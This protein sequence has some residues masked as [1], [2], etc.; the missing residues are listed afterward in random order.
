MRLPPLQEVLPE[1]YLAAVLH[2]E[3]RRFQVHPGVDPLAILGATWAN[4]RAGRRVRGGSTLTMQVIRMARRKPRTYL[5][6]LIEGLQAVRFELHHSKEEILRHYATHVPMGGNIVGVEAASWRY[7]GRPFVDLSWAE[8]ALFAV[9]PNNPSLINLR[10]GR[11]L[12]RVKRDKLLKVMFDRKVFDAATYALACLEPLPPQARPLPF[13][14]PHFTEL[15]L[16]RSSPQQYLTTT[17]DLEVQMVL[18]H[19]ARPHGES[20]RRQGITNLAAIVVDSASGKVRGY[21]GSLDYFS[22]QDQG[23]VDGVLARRSTGSL[24]KPFLVAKVFDRGPFT[25]NSRIQDVPTFYGTF[26][27]QNASKTYQGFA[28]ISEV[29]QKSLNVPAVRLLHTYGVENFL[30]FLHQTGFRGLFRSAEQYGL[31]L[32]LGGAEA[33]L[34]ELTRAY[35]SFNHGGRRKDLVL[36]ERV[37]QQQEVPVQLF[38]AGSAHLVTEI[39]MEV[40]RPGIY[41]DQPH[42]S[43]ARSFAWKTGTSY[44]QKDA[45]AIGYDGQWTIGVWCGN[46]DGT[47]NADLSGVT[48]AGPLLLHLFQTLSKGENRT[49]PQ[50]PDGELRSISC[51]MRSGYPTGPHCPETVPVFVPREQQVLRN[52][53]YHQRIQVE[54]GGRYRLCSKCWEGRM[55]EYVTRF[56]P[57]AS[58]AAVYRDHGIPVDEFPAHLPGCPSDSASE[59]FELVYPVPGLTIS[60][61]RNF[62]GVRE[63]VV[64]SAHHQRKTAS[65]FW[66]LDGH[67]ITETQ[68][69]HAIAIEVSA[70]KHSLTVQDEQGGTRIAPFNLQ[71]DD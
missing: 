31:T 6:K 62:D 24:L 10:Q 2:Y 4:V 34:F 26:A 36:L 49:W 67:F 47:G 27:P 9:L 51:C 30:E 43:G 1:K 16:S 8:A 42:L 55:R 46:F 41:Q 14:A 35:L 63:K 66:F 32:I 64:F 40:P 50:A 38:S 15:V 20:L 69:D 60:P 17:L 68:D 53:P 70:G 61:P 7:L 44:G 28:R 56:V 71:I 5:N 48:S 19:L 22:H 59:L 3:D 54:T 29:L 33:S 23:Q 25:V 18:E 21:L 39:L 13:T 52:C 65:L 58:V 12:L 11:S 45:W 37:E 57:P